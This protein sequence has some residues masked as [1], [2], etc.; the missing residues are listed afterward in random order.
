MTKKEKS[1]PE[2]WNLWPQLLANRRKLEKH[3]EIYIKLLEKMGLSTWKGQ[4]L[5]QRAI[6]LLKELDLWELVIY[7]HLWLEMNR[8]EKKAGRKRKQFMKTRQSLSR[9]G[10]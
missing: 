5:T 4:E 10:R 1:T 8:L 6:P 2:R 7:P 3:L 9:K